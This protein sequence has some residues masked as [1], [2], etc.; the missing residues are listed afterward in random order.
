MSEDYSA[1]IQ[2]IL[3]LVKCWFNMFNNSVSLAKLNKENNSV[4]IQ[5]SWIKFN[6]RVNVVKCISYK[7]LNPAKGKAALQT[8]QFSSIQSS[9]NVNVEQLTNS[10]H[11]RIVIQFSFVQ[12]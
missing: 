4:I 10:I 1:I 7:T 8:S 9:V 5:H 3:S 12:C 2:L 6:N 11:S